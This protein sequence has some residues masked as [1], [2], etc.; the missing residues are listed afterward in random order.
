MEE[1]SGDKSDVFNFPEKLMEESSGCGNGK[2]NL[3]VYL[4]N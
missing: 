1:S 4:K 2:V 3:M